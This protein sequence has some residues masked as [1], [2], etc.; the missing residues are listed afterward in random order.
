MIV[1]QDTQ[2]D[3]LQWK[4]CIL[5]PQWNSNKMYIHKYYYLIRF[6]VTK[7]WDSINGT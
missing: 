1:L 2:T 5:S 3:E 4:H 7:R 6:K